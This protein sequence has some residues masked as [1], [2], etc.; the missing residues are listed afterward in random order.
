MMY[1]LNMKK[2]TIVNHPNVRLPGLTAVP[3]SDDLA[4]QVK[5]LV[6]VIVF[7]KIAGIEPKRHE[8]KNLYRLKDGKPK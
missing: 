3:V 6:D 2:G 7:D 5:H 1:A 4:N 8:A